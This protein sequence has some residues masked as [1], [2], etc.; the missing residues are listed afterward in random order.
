MINQ[1]IHRLKLLLFFA[2]LMFII[3]N[4]FFCYR[5]LADDVI[6]NDETI[7]RLTNL[8]NDPSTNEEKKEKCR[9]LIAEI[10][11]IKPKIIAQI[12]K[13]HDDIIRSS[14]EDSKYTQVSSF[15][16][17]YLYSPKTPINP[18]DSK[19]LE[20]ISVCIQ[21]IIDNK[22]NIKFLLDQLLVATKIQDMITIYE[23]LK[24][25]LDNNKNS[26]DKIKTNKEQLTLSL[27][28][29][30]FST[31]L[32]NLNSDFENIQMKSVPEEYKNID[33]LIGGTLQVIKK[34]VTDFLPQNNPNT[35]NNLSETTW[36]WSLI[37]IS[38]LSFFIIILFHQKKKKKYHKSSYFEKD[39]F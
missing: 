28:S 30:S 21:S 17:D 24:I 31:G 26:L 34:N 4:S 23:P 5:I 11:E 19:L 8:M 29:T 20:E 16:N 32:E 22:Q 38:L 35:T 2:F 27:E 37:L 39:K 13:Y 18:N 3:F 36:W 1:P 6:E 9:S 25:F 33:T 15:I 14:L 7:I 10:N 12:K